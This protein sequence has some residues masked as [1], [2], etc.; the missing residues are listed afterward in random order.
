MAR[1]DWPVALLRAQHAKP[2]FNLVFRIGSRHVYVDIP[3][4]YYEEFLEAVTALIIRR[5]KELN[6][7]VEQGE[8]ELRRVINDIVREAKEIANKYNE[9]LDNR[10]LG[11]FR[12]RVWRNA[13]ASWSKDKGGHLLEK[14]NYI[15]GYKIS[16]RRF[17][18]F[19][20]RFSTRNLPWSSL[21]EYYSYINFDYKYALLEALYLQGRRGPDLAG[22]F[23]RISKSVF[24]KVSQDIVE[25]ESI[26]NITRKRLNDLIARKPPRSFFRRAMDYVI[27]LAL[28]EIDSNLAGL[29]ELLPWSSYI[30]TVLRRLIDVVSNV[31]SLAVL[32]AKDTVIASGSRELLIKLSEAMITIVNAWNDEAYYRKC[33]NR[34]LKLNSLKKPEPIIL[35]KIKDIVDKVLERSGLEAEISKSKLRDALGDSAS[36]STIIL[37]WALA[38]QKGENDY[39]IT[40]SDELV[41]LAASQLA[42]GLGKILRL[43]PSSDK[44]EKLV[45][46]LYST[47]KS[48]VMGVKTALPVPRPGLFVDI[49]EQYSKELGLGVEPKKLYEDYSGFVHSALS[50]LQLYPFTSVL[51][52]KLLKHELQYSL[53]TVNLLMEAVATGQVYQKFKADKYLRRAKQL[54][55]R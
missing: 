24:E 48:Q 3:L 53:F 38:E 32:M 27:F 46:E 23:W 44:Y 26:I 54:I 9:K 11:W 34:G 41:R 21:Y 35:S 12:L 39:V 16:W 2:E 50:L 47:L 52:Y 28:Q 22:T 10:G 25:S 18:E 45:L 49:A 20:E 7:A 5:A 36:I 55:A 42:R 15:L 51:E 4:R 37:L 8:Y 13:V 30:Y 19:V 14:H 31:Y 17:N 33:M 40:V 29:I 1:I 43:N 6:Q